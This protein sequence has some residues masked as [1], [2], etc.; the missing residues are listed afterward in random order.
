MLKI[1]TVIVTYNGEKWIG[2]CLRSIEQSSIDSKV[3]IVDNNSTDN[4]I[5]A[6]EKNFRDVPILKK[7]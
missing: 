5:A 3:I 6:I 7:I 2:D 4:T 1:F